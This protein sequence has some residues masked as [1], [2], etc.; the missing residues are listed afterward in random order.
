M[1]TYT[2]EYVREH[3]HEKKN[4]LWY[5]FQHMHLTPENT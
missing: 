5:I 4:S 1:L 3:L 2:V